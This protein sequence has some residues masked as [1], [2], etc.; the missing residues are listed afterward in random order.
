MNIDRRRFFPGGH[1]G[2]G[3][4]HISVMCCRSSWFSLGV[5]T[6]GFKYYAGQCWIDAFLNTAMLLGGMGPVGEI[7]S[8]GGKVFAAMFALYAGLFFIAGMAV[9]AAPVL[10]RVLHKLHADETSSGSDVS[11][12]DNASPPLHGYN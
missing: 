5:G 8:S 4:R 2:V 3:S 9:I 7:H 12:S 6:A 10:H 11:A 1:S